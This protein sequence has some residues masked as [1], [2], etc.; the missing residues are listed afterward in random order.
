MERFKLIA[1]PSD[2][3]LNFWGREFLRTSQSCHPSFRRCSRTSWVC[4]S[5][6]IRRRRWDACRD[7]LECLQE[8]ICRS[9]RDIG[10]SLCSSRQ[11]CIRPCP[12][13]FLCSPWLT[14]LLRLWR[15]SWL[16]QRQRA[17]PVAFSLSHWI[18]CSTRPE[19]SQ[20]D[21]EPSVTMSL[22]FLWHFSAQHSS[23][24]FLQPLSQSVVLFFV[25]LRKKVFS[26][27]EWR[28][29]FTQRVEQWLIKPQIVWC[30]LV[31]LH[32][33]CSRLQKLRKRSKKSEKSLV[34]CSFFQASTMDS[35]FVCFYC[36]AS[37]F[38]LCCMHNAMFIHSEAG[39]P[40]A[41]SVKCEN[42][43]TN[44]QAAKATRIK[45]GGS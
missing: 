20:S 30:N 45:P 27:K 15:R 33:S 21:L 10:T 24:R 9:S 12:S 44:R 22:T 13:Y 37:F 43:R 26:V 6:A 38:P 32:W 25:F 18:C 28:R 23:L 17:L 34:R 31:W 42:M 39:L 8:R 5:S 36:R 4:P 2:Q 11:L 14:R 7:Q 29:N 3:D 1:L 40:S 41:L 35:I 16:L 19:P